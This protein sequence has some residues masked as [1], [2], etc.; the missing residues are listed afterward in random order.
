M[1]TYDLFTEEECLD[2]INTLDTKDK[3]EYCLGKIRSNY[4]VT[5]DNNFKYYDKVRLLSD[6]NTG[7]ESYGVLYFLKY[8]L[9]DYYGQH[10]DRVNISEQHH[11]GLFNLNC[12]L[13]DN[14]EGGEF[15]LKGDTISTVIGSAYTYESTIPHEVTKVTSGV[16]YVMMYYVRERDVINQNKQLL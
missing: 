12:I 9:G 10:I 1:K 15:K 4:K 6:K 11:D 16:R 2:I 14:F 7:Y 13:N 5:V 3:W 8:N